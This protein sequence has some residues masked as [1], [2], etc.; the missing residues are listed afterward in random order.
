VSRDQRPLVSRFEYGKVGKH[1]PN[2]RAIFHLL[3]S[4]NGAIVN[5]IATVTNGDVWSV[6]T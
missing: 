6:Q 4:R 1:S 2:E 3:R 5:V